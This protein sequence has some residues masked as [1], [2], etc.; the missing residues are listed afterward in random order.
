MRLLTIEASIL[1]IA[2]LFSVSQVNAVSLKSQIRKIDFN[3]FMY[4]GFQDKRIYLKNG[5]QEIT[6]EC[7]GTIYSLDDV[8]YVDF[9]GDRREEALVQITDFSGCGSSCL[10]YN[11]YIY[12]IRHN[13]PHLLWKLASGCQGLGGVKRSHLKGREMIF[14]VFGVSKIVGSQVVGG[15][16]GG[17]CCP[18]HFTRI[19]VA[20]DG[21]RF[22]Q[23]SIKV[24][25]LSQ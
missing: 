8:A 5:K 14:E 18:K 2:L 1:L 21:R 10:T 12:G 15:D 11:Y 13:R 17:E 4:P 22:R 6:R 20:W 16:S 23:R 9:T 3:N 25:P 7:G 19:R 24:F